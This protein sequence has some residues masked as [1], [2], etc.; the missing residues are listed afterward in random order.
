MFS[1]VT[2]E[3]PLEKLLLFF[4]GYDLVLLEGYFLESVM[5]IEVHCAELGE[6]LT[7]NMK[8]VLAILSGAAANQVENLASLIEEWMTV[9]ESH[10]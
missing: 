10:A 9:K 3:T 1:N 8:N 2:E 4:E 7:R 5:K 6:P